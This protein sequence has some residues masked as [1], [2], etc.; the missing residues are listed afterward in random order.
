[1]DLLKF[2]SSVML[3]KVCILLSCPM[4]FLFSSSHVVYL[5]FL[6]MQ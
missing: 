6:L 3:F 2:Y 5:H 4:P 1:M